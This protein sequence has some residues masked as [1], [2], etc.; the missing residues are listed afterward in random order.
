MKT[1]VY[2][3]KKDRSLIIA[4]QNVKKQNIFMQIMKA[5]YAP[6]IDSLMICDDNYNIERELNFSIYN[7]WKILPFV[8]TN[9]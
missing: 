3:A 6:A 5:N 9:L 8:E 2:F 4:Y 1:D 7:Q